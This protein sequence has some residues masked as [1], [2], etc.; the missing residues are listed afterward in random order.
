MTTYLDNTIVSIK[1]TGNG[2]TG[3]IN[4]L[5]TNP[6]DLD[7]GLLRLL[8]KNSITIKTKVEDLIS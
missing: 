4:G 5:L 8:H 7:L 2:K 6:K 3:F 1:E